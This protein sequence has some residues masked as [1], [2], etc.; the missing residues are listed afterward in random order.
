MSQKKDLHPLS[1]HIIGWLV[2]GVLP[3][4]LAE[5][6]AFTL[7]KPVAPVCITCHVS[8]RNVFS[9]SSKAAELLADTDQ[10][11]FV[12]LLQ[13]DLYVDDGIQC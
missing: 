2:A 9:N 5:I 10:P 12:G 4:W 13:I 11:M 6:T 7:P 3:F 8:F 1:C